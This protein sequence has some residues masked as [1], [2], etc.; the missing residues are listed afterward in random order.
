MRILRISSHANQIIFV[1]LAGLICSFLYLR[2]MA[3]PN[4]GGGAHDCGGVPKTCGAW[5][6]NGAN[7]C[8]T[9][10]QAQCTT[11]N[12]QEVI[13]GNKKTTE[14]YEGHGAPPA[15]SI[16]PPPSHQPTHRT[17]PPPAGV[18]RQ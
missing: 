13:A 6:T 5:G 11:Q 18:L 17:P 3:A 9:C 7:T 14:C 10:N 2:A 16:A 12:G 15:G 8:R 1:A 4:I